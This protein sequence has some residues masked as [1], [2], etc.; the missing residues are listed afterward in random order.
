[1]YTRRRR[2]TPAPR[3]AQGALL[4]AMCALLLGGGRAPR[5]DV[6]PAT[7]QAADLASSTD[8]SLSQTLQAEAAATA[9]W[10][11][12]LALTPTATGEP[13]PTLA[14]PGAEGTPLASL[15]GVCEVADG[16]RLHERDTFCITAPAGWKPLNIDGGVAA[17]LNTTPGQAVGL[18]PDWA[19][20]PAV[21]SLMV[22]V[23][24]GSSAAAHL[25]SSYNSFKA[26]ADIV[27]LSE[28]RMQSLGDYAIPGF[29]WT[30][31]SGETGGVYADVISLNRLV[32]I[33]HSGTQCR[34]DDLLPAISTLRF[35]MGR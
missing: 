8:P 24:P 27:E 35:S 26:R 10:V 30:A 23:T 15:S 25:E 19:E 12:E 4:L 22:Y 21:C 3:V 34:A 16:F 20:E 6:P 7:A 11:A 28:M 32:H 1:M 18:Q 9:A 13:L 14:V 31:S 33:S 2:R 29:T 17:S 5:D